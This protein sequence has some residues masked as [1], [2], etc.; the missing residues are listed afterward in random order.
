MRPKRDYWHKNLNFYDRSNFDKFRDKKIEI[1]C[2]LI[3]DHKNTL[4]KYFFKLFIYSRKALREE[5]FKHKIG[6][7]ALAVL[8][9]FVF[10]DR[11]FSIFF[12]FCEIYKAKVNL[13]KYIPGT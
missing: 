1:F 4:V 7:I 12:Q 8:R 3:I 10:K 13:S 6:P 5:H 2:R 9:Q 11:C